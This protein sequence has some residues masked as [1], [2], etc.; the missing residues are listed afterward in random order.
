MNRIGL[1]LLALSL[2][3]TGSCDGGSNTQLA[4]DQPADRDEHP[5]HLEDVAAKSGLGFTHFAGDSGNFRLP[6]I[7]AGGAGLLDFDGD[8]DLDVLLTQ[9][10]FDER[11]GHTASRAGK[12]VVEGSRLY[13]NDLIPEGEFRFTDVTI[14]ANL[15]TQGYAMGVAVGDIDNDGFSDVYVSNYGR[16]QLFH[17]RADGTFEDI[18]IQSGIEAIRWSTSA[19]FFD[20][21]L[22]GDLDLFVSHYLNSTISNHKPCPGPLGQLEYCAPSAYEPVPDRLYRNDG[23]LRFTEVTEAAG[24]GAATGPGLGVVAGDF[25][26]D[27]WPDLY[28]AND[29]DANQLWMNQGDGTFEDQALLAGTAYNDAGDA[30]AGMGITAGDVDRDGDE[31]LL[32]THLAGETNT[33]YLNIGDGFF[34]DATREFG[35]AFSSLRLTGFG[36]ALVDLDRDGWLDLYVANG[37]I[38]A[39]PGIDDGFPYA[40]PDLVLRN[41]EGRYRDITDD[42]GPALRSERVGRSVATGDIDNDGNVDL[43]VTNINERPQLL[44]NRTQTPGSWLRIKLIGKSSNR[45]AIGARV[46]VRFEDGSAYW[47]QVRRDG[48]FMAAND[49]RVHVGVAPGQSIELIEVR[50]PAGASETWDA[51]RLNA[52]LVLE[53]GSGKAA[54]GG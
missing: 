10:V 31:D 53:E 15:K 11:M 46:G 26:D 5:I 23:E 20:Y 39:Q 27:G 18:T 54:G 14:D 52:E 3:A 28:V 49:P 41:E 47:T 24:L 33:L 12:A 34:R 6:E 44:L 30:E 51:P 4:D 48:S 8:G 21:D 22:D 50:W 16:D 17:N 1:G 19:S 40:Q 35:I 25:N 32:V 43:L 36:V 29:G 42:V 37:A 7:I 2:L 13:R 9:A 38:K 45:D